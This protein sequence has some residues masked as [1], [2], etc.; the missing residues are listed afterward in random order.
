VIKEQT[1]ERLARMAERYRAHVETLRGPEPAQA[2]AA[3]LAAY[4][5]VVRP[6]VMAFAA[7]LEKAGHEASFD[8]EARPPGLVFRILIDG[9]D[10]QV[11]RF[12]WRP[13]DG[14]TEESVAMLERAH[15]PFELGRFDT[16]ADIK[17]DVVEHLLVEALEQI[18]AL[19]ASR[20]AR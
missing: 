10:E 19:A 2:E 3:H 13:R 18:F 17:H 9:R 7:E 6:V 5:D 11:I 15:H 4:K 8:L 14:R 16:P 1:K 12:S 20:A